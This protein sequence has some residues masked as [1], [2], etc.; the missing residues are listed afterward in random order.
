MTLYGLSEDS[1][2]TFS[3]QT[4]TQGPNQPQNGYIGQ[5]WLLNT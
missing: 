4:I 1:M 5:L 2:A 3:I